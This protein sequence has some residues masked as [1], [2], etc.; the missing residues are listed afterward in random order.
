MMTNEVAS[1]A[2]NF[3]FES[4]PATATEKLTQQ[5]LIQLVVIVVMSRMVA[6]LLKRVFGQ[7]EV[8]GEIIAGLILGPSLFGALFPHAFA[9][10]FTG[11]V[12][13]VFAGL[14]QIGLIFLMFEIG[15]EFEFRRLLSTSRIALLIVSAASILLPFVLAVLTAPFFY[16]SIDGGGKSLLA[17]RLFFGVAVSITALPIL[18]R[19]FMELDLSHTR[20]S[21]LT[22]GAAAI[23]DLAGWLLLG[24]VTAAITS[25]FNAG[26]SMLRMGVLLGYMAIVWF[27][28]RPFL[29]K[30]VTASMRGTTEI[31]GPL[32]GWISAALFCSAFLTS[33]LGVFANIGGF[34]AGFALHENRKFAN[35]WKQQVAPIIK[36]VFL[37]LFFVYTGL[38]VNITALH[39]TMAIFTCLAII[40]VSFSGK[41]VGA[42]LAARFVRETPRN[43]IVIGIC[44]NTRALM[45]LIV[46]NIG[47]DLGVLSR[48]MFSMLVLMAIASTVIT[49]PLLRLLMSAERRKSGASDIAS[50]VGAVGAID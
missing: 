33:W 5:I 32:I 11:T 9:F 31:S 13:R 43:S 42:W 7:T 46:L 12:D 16:H 23:N 49:T 21:A 41:F 34:I 35:A 2:S 47:L 36:V 25:G 20:I 26:I 48:N 19:I 6:A 8:V 39:G 37:P 10:I 45:E 24:G 3:F 15:V 4:A 40:A 29:K 30:R 27:V 17:F 38:R 18:G 14:A 44:M 22:I 1:L 28:A 50:A